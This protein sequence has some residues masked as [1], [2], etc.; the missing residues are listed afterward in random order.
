MVYD[1]N[2]LNQYNI[3]DLIFP[4]IE[5]D[6]ERSTSVT[7]EDASSNTMLLD[8][9]AIGVL[10]DRSA[11]LS[12][13]QLLPYSEK[14]PDGV[15][16]ENVTVPVLILWGEFD[17]MMPANQIYRYTWALKNSRVTTVKIPRAGHF[18]GIDQPELVSEYVLN[19]LINS[20]GKTALADI[21]LGYTGIWKGDEAEMIVKLRKLYGM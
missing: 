11:V 2:K 3:R 14:N 20:L 9:N 13:S 19:F 17:N 1:P 12:P 4:Y 5:V 7:G 8:M 21:F 16:Y 10:A 15:K 6:Y 18:A